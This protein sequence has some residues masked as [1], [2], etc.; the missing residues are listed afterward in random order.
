[1][2]FATEF[3]YSQLVV[4]GSI[5]IIYMKYVDNSYRKNFVAVITANRSL[6]VGSHNIP[7]ID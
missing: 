6:I 7:N 4:F 1:M 5:Y 2:G 3:V